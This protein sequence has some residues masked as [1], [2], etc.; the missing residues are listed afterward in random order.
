MNIPALR[1]WKSECCSAGTEFTT[2]R[3]IPL[4]LITTYPNRYDLSPR[5]TPNNVWTTLRVHPDQSYPTNGYNSLIALGAV[6]QIVL[7]DLATYILRS[8]YSRIGF[9]GPEGTVFTSTGVFLEPRF[10][11][12]IITYLQENGILDYDQ[13]FI[14]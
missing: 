14:R 4:W 10:R 2:F 7:Y 8:R 11:R 12:T 13:G 9:V 1:K 3:E 5:T 6:E